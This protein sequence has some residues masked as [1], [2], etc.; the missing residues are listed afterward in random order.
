MPA[1]QPTKKIYR[2]AN[3]KP[4]DLD[5]LTSRNELT[6]A[7]SNVKMNARGDELGPGGKI[8]RKREDILRDYYNQGNKM[9]E[10][11][12]EKATPP[13]IGWEEDD[14]GDFVET[15]SKPSTTRKK[16]V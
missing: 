1:K 5:S 12:V 13:E 14:S 9:A 2:S 16:N 6:T 11:V 7:V 8:V 3:G 15:S 10:E 4:I